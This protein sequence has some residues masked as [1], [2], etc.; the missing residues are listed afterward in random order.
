MKQQFIAVLK[1]VPHLLEERNWTERERKIVEQHFA[2]LQQLLKEGTLLLAGRTLP[3]DETRM[4]I[5]ILEVNSE[6]EA[7]QIMES[8]ECVNGGVMTVQVLPF[9]VALSR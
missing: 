8:D 5:V 4:G 2:R 9:K 3:L 1:L 7:R 6:A